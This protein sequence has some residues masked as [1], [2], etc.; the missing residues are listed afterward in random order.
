MDSKAFKAFLVKNQNKSYDLMAREWNEKHPDD[1]KTSEAVRKAYKALGLPPKRINI[2]NKELPIEAQVEKDSTVQRLRENK[3]T[4]DKKYNHVLQL[5]RVK[6]QAFE[7]MVSLKATTATHAIKATAYKGGQATA[8]LVA[9]DWHVEEEV[10]DG[11]VSGVNR[12]NL[13]IARQRADHFFANGVR[14][15]KLFQKDTE[16]KNIV[17]PLLG[18]FISGNLHEDSNEKNQL[19]AME[20]I[21]FAKELIAS[22]VRYMLKE[23]DCDLQFVC[24]SGNHGRITKR[25]HWGTE[26]QNSLEW[27]MYR[28]LA[29][30]FKDEKRVKF[31]IPEGDMS[32]LDVYDMKIRLIHGHQVK[33]GGGVGGITI[34]MRKAIAQWD[35]VQQADLTVFGHFHQRIDGG[36]FIGNGS[37][38][39]YNAYAQAMKCEFERPAQQFFLISNRNGGEKSVVAPIWLD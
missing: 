5:L 35:R 31:V 24:H 18:D 23:T 21:E 1:N 34:P 36:N 27:L 11:Q 37:L 28:S 12:Y 30:M 13:S 38:I 33:Y 20:A 16:I 9:S 39:G 6:D 10:R 7:A 3:Q 2:Q 25:I 14:L 19:G 29:F 8:V 17:V 22:G 4:G 15:V 26:N 32:Y